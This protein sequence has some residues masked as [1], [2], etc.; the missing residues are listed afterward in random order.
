MYI[1][2]YSIYTHTHT[3]AYFNLKKLIIM[4]FICFFDF[5]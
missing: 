2:V 4:K 1:Y 3:H 5:P